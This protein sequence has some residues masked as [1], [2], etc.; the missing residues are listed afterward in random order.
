M[1]GIL[2]PKVSLRTSTGTWSPSD[3]HDTDIN[4]VDFAVAVE[5]GIAWSVP[6]NKEQAKI[7]TIDDAIGIKIRRAAL[8]IGCD[9]IVRPWVVQKPIDQTVAI[10][11]CKCWAV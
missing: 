11:V 9:R 3:K 7:S 1:V 10:G 8:F 2:N 6:L 5:V 4:A